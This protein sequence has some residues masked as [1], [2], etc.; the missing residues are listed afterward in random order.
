MTKQ[1]IFGYGSLV[2]RGDLALYLGEEKPQ[3]EFVK[4]KGLKRDWS[5]AMDNRADVPNYKYYVNAAQERVDK[6]IAFLNV[7]FDPNA[8]INGVIFPVDEAK[9]PELDA[10]ERNYRRVEISHLSQS[11]HQGRVWTYM[12]KESSRQRFMEGLAQDKV[13]IQKAYIDFVLAAFRAVGY[14]FLFDFI[15]STDFHH[16][17][18]LDLKRRTSE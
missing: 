5:V 2:D 1:Y 15:K 17:P 16:L 9:L 14:H 8:E 10:R 11:V 6:Y 4:F 3:Y 18:V 7:S 13:V 12:A